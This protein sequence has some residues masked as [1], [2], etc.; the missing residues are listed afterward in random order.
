MGYYTIRLSPAI[1]DMTA[2]VTE[3]GKF[4]YN[5]LPMSLC[6]SGDIFQYKLDELLGDIE[7]VKTYINDILVLNKDCS[8]KHIEQL[9][10][11][12]GKLHCRIKS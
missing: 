11:I 12:F 10:M 9:I 6:A 5:C 2:I 4:I 8:V 3:F 1:Q 7:S